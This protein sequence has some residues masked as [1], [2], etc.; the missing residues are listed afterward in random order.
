MEQ[1]DETPLERAQRQLIEAEARVAAQLALIA[2]MDR[3]NYSTVDEEIML[4]D[5]KNRLQRCHEEL[6]RQRAHAGQ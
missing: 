1:H 4:D 2:E 5:L 3:Q 6:A